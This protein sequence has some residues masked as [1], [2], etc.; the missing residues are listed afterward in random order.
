MH[1]RDLGRMT[2]RAFARRVGRWALL[3]VL[4]APT[5]PLR[6]QE[7]RLRAEPAGATLEL[8]VSAVGAAS[9]REPISVVGRAL[10][11]D[12]SSGALDSA[13]V[14]ACV[15]LAPDGAALLLATYARA[16]G[17]ATGDWPTDLAR[18]L[19]VCEGGE[20]WT[21][22]SR[23]GVPPRDRFARISAPVVGEREG[24]WEGRITIELSCRVP[25]GAGRTAIRTVAREYL[26]RWDGRAWTLY[27][28]ASRRVS[29]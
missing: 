6:A 5:V 4:C 14:Q 11:C 29:D 21:G 3:G 12:A 15:T 9:R 24:Q 28:V 19:P 25:G 10:N 1:V 8:L 20:E 23:R 17:R 2:A 26:C 27:Q 13:S 22:S 16:L 18:E 7:A